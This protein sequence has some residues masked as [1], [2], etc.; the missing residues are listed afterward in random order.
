MPPKSWKPRLGLAHAQVQTGCTPLV[1]KDN[2][3]EKKTQI[4]L[5]YALLALFLVFMFQSWWVSYRQV[6][7]IPYSEFEAL[8]EKGEIEEVAVHQN[9]LEGK[10]KKPLPDGR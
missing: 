1:T 3:M 6:E 7:P 2:I 5:W 4:N 8:L 10:L 9:Y